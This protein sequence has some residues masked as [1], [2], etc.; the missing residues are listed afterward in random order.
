MKQALKYLM[1]GLVLVIAPCCVVDTL[2]SPYV[3]TSDEAKIGL[4]ERYKVSTNSRYRVDEWI[5]AKSLEIEA[6]L[7]ASIATKLFAVKMQKALPLDNI[8]SIEGMRTPSSSTAGTL[9][10]APVSTAGNT[11]E[12][13]KTM[14]SG[15][16]ALSPSHATMA[17]ATTPGDY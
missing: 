17:P 9:S 13:R 14:T 2:P 3:S 11:I 12:P 10:T 16:T 6:S 15:P 4:I 5:T 8:Q 1:I 7:Y